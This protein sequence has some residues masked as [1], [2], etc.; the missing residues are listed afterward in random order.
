[1]DPSTASSAW[2]ARACAVRS[3]RNAAESR[4][5]IAAGVTSSAWAGMATS[6]AA[7]GVAGAAGAKASARRAATE[8][9]DEELATDA[10][11]SAPISTSSTSS[12]PERTREYTTWPA[13]NSVKPHSRASSA[14]LRCPSTLHSS[15]HA[16]GSIAIS[17]SLWPA[18]DSMGTASGPC[19]T[20][21]MASHWTIRRATSSRSSSTGVGGATS[22]RV[23]S[24]TRNFQVPVGQRSRSLVCS[25]TCSLM[26]ASTTGWSTYPRW[27]SSSPSRQPCSSVRWASRA[28]ASAS[29]PSEPEDTRR[30]PSWGRRPGT[31]T[32]YT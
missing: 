23:R 15:D 8:P 16:S 3:T 29:G 32:E 11:T 1:M 25:R 30:A 28:S 27:T 19:R 21:V 7:S 26:K 31:C 2:G 5:A 6:W 24:L 14:T 22:S 4:E 13:S 20:S 12:R 17:E 9:A 10:G 18:A